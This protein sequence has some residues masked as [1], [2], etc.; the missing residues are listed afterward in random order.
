MAHFLPQVGIPKLGEEEGGFAQYPGRSVAE[1]HGS[2]MNLL[3][4]EQEHTP[5]RGQCALRG[6]GASEETEINEGGGGRGGEGGGK[7]RQGGG[8]GEGG[9]GELK[10]REAEGNCSDQ[11]ATRR[12]GIL[13]GLFWV[14]I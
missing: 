12:R 1:H 9:S 11:P 4:N 6:A 5:A 7:R 8:G 14:C 10:P 13:C 3:R 2:Y